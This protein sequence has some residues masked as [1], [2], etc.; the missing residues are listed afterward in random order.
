[1]DYDEELSAKAQKVTDA[2]NRIGGQHLEPVGIT[3]APEIS[4]LTFT[5]SK[6]I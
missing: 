4:V 5:R 1:M 3:G 2:L 6:Y